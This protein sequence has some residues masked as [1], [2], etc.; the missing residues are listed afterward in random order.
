[1]GLIQRSERVEEQRLA[2][3]ARLLGAIEDGDPAHA[4]GSAAGQLARRERPV[5][6]DLRDAH[7]FAL[8]LQVGD[9]LACGLAA[10]AHH[11]EHALGLRVA[12]VLDQAIATAGPLGETVHRALHHVRA[13]ARRTG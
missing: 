1:M 11:H 9:R 6:P 10:R 5:E 12:A 4:L 2:E 7:A 13:R 3:R 8:R